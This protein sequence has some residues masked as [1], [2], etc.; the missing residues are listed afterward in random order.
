MNFYRANVIGLMIA[1]FSITA[2]AQ[3]QD[4]HESSCR[5]FVQDFYNWYV[6]RDARDQKIRDY[7][8]T[9]DDV[10]RL[11]PEALS[12][13]LRRLLQKD[14]TAQ[15]HSQDIVGLDFDPFFNSQDPSPEFKVQTVTVQGNRCHAVVHGIEREQIRESIEPDLIL[16]DGK[17]VFVNFH[18]GKS[19]YSNDENL[20]DTLQMLRNERNKPAK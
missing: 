15:A 5:T 17:W 6:A 7:G 13:E 4:A 11:K 19:D 18:Y 10:L 3:G 9:S 20:I 12:P 2:P 8:P 16:E 14:S 1:L